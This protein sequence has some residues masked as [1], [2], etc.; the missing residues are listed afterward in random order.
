MIWHPTEEVV[1]VLVT[2]LAPGWWLRLGQ[3]LSHP[4]GIAFNVS[5]TRQGHWCPQSPSGLLMA[6][7][8]S[9]C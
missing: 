8:C 4:L 3:A 2:L 6:Y 5:L 1:G 9:G 7:Y